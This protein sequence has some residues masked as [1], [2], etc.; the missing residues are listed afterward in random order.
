M[1]G[2]CFLESGPW[3]DGGCDG[4]QAVVQLAGDML[5]TVRSLPSLIH[6]GTLAAHESF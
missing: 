5:A 3:E 6:S 2:R 4:C 1:L